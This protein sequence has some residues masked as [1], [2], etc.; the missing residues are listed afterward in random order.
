MEEVKNLVITFF[1]ENS[2]HYIPSS[3][4]N[5]EDACAHIIN[6]G[7]SI[8]CTRW[9]VGYPGGSFV[10]AIVNNDLSSAML[11]ADGINKQCMEFYVYMMYSIPKPASM[12]TKFALEELIA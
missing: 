2:K 8:L 4:I 6:I 11:R 1:D 7:A 9:D 12:N 5:D 3:L 10:Q